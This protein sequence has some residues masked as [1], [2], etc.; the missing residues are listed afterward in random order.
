MAPRPHVS[1]P[2]GIEGVLV[3]HHRERNPVGSL[4]QGAPDH[5]FVLAARTQFS[6]VAGKVGMALSQSLTEI[7][8]R[9]S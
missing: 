2:S 8:D 5:A 7:D 1:P 9:L 3:S 4:P 6:G